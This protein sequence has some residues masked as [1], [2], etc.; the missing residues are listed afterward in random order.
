MRTTLAA[1]SVIACSGAALADVTDPA[2]IAPFEFSQV[3]I[4]WIGSRAS[5]TGNLQWIDPA[6]STVGGTLF[7]NKT[8][9]TGESYEIPRLYAQGERVDFV[10]DI[11]RG[12]LDT[13]STAV[14]EDWIQFRVDAT[15]ATNVLVQIEDI[16]LPRGDADYNDAEFRVVFTQSIPAPGSLALLGLAPA[17]ALRRRR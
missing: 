15:D 8:A 7:D 3:E 2:I 5:Y 1:V 12:G 16:R 11:V 13:F 14:E 17:C 10:Y 4:Q 9:A 6:V